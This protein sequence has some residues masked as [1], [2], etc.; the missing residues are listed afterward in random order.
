MAELK[1][2]LL[3]ERTRSGLSQ[4]ALSKKIGITW[5]AYQRYEAGERVPPVS[6]LVAL[7]DEYGCSADYLLGR[8]DKQ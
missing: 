4:A 8:T 5:R 3:E 1:E 2:R 6:V 7:C